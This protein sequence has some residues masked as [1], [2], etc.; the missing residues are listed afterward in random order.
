[1]L[2]WLFGKILYIH[3][4]YIKIKI[5]SC[6][7]HYKLSFFP[8]PFNEKT[9]FIFWGSCKTASFP[10]K[11][12]FNLFCFHKVLFNP[13]YFYTVFLKYPILCTCIVMKIALLLTDYSWIH[14]C[15]DKD[16]Q[17]VFLD[18]QGFINSLMCFQLSHENF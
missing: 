18:L 3:S 1:M 6:S 8:T 12:D 15:F 5:F 2:I 13:Y 9:I 14:L 4:I 10:W 16:F 11:Y 7:T 17:K